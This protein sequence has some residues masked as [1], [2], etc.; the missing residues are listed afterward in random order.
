[1]RSFFKVL[2]RGKV[3]KRDQNAVEKIFGKR[4]GQSSLLRGLQ[5]AGE[6]ARI[7]AH[8]GQGFQRKTCCD[9][10]QY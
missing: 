2:L 5:S 8:A 1:M 7:G 6:I 10:F 4:V 3:R 9:E